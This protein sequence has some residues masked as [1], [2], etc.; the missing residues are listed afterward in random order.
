MSSHQIALLP[1]VLKRLK[2]RDQ[3]TSFGFGG[4]RWGKQKGACAEIKLM[5][6]KKNM[7]MDLL[8][9]CTKIE[10]HNTQ[11]SE[12]FSIKLKLSDLTQDFLFLS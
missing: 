9:L 12:I 5:Q 6:T 4:A 8:H 7:W 3:R 11:A 1:D 10:K 2:D